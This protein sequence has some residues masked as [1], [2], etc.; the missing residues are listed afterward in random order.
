ML[1]AHYYYDGLNRLEREDNGYIGKTVV[2][3]YNSGGD[4]LS[5]TEYALTYS[6]TLGEV[7]NVIEYRYDD[8]NHLNGVTLYDETDII[9]YDTLGRTQSISSTY[10][11]QIHK[12][13]S[14][15][16]TSRLSREITA[17]LLYNNSVDILLTSI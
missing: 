15:A 6:E 12:T 10:N 14:Q 1:K 3:E 11:S 8:L 7:T 2:Y 5:R 4:I 13:K 17:C 16:V 9:G